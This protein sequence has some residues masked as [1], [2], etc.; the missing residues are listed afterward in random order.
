MKTGAALKQRVYTP[1]LPGPSWDADTGYRVVEVIPG[2]W[3]LTPP[4]G[5]QTIALT[6]LAA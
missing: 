4:P 6:I 2:S 5:G 1:S 3:G